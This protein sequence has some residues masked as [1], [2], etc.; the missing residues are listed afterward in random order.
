VWCVGL[1]RAVLC[2]LQALVRRSQ[3]LQHLD[4]LEHALADAQRVSV[5][6]SCAAAPSLRLCAATVAN[7]QQQHV[8]SSDTAL[9]SHWRHSAADAATGGGTAVCRCLI[10]RAAGFRSS[11]STNHGGGG[12]AS[13][14]ACR[15]VPHLPCASDASLMQLGFS[16]RYMYLNRVWLSD[17]DCC[18][19]GVGT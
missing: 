9:L 11:I 15:R 3:A 19:A 18:C 1:C 4:D 12:V 6:C 17:T 13:C 7:A 14:T 2:L 16:D 10:L 5:P 8:D